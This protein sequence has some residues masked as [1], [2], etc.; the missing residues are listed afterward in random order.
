MSDLVMCRLCLN[1]HTDSN[2]V[3]GEKLSAANVHSKLEKYL[4]LVVDTDDNITRSI[5]EKCIDRL[6]DF[7]MFY[8]QVTQN[9]SVLRTIEQIEKQDQLTTIVNPTTDY[10]KIEM[11]NGTII[12]DGRQVYK[13]E[14]LSVISQTD[15]SENIV[16]LGS[17]HVEEYTD[18]NVDQEKT[19]DSNVIV[20]EINETDEDLQEEEK[21]YEIVE[22]SEQ[23]T[24][25]IASSRQFEMDTELEMNTNKENSVHNRVTSS[26]ASKRRKEDMPSEDLKMD[27]EDDSDSNDSY[28]FE[29]ITP[30]HKIE[31]E[32]SNVKH[33]VD[34]L[35][36][37]DDDNSEDGGDDNNARSV[38]PTELI[39]DSRLIIRGKRLMKYMSKFYRLTCDICPENSNTVFQK[40]K[41]LC[42]HYNE[43]HSIKGYVMCCGAKL[44][45][46]RAM[47]MHM[48]R[49]LQPEA[50][51]CPECDKSMTHPKILQYHI[52]N[53]LPEEQRPLACPD[54]PRRFSYSS[55]LVAHAISHQPENER[56]VHICDECGKSFSSPG[57]LSTHTSVVHTKH[58]EVYVCHICAK[59]FG[60]KG[61]LVY[62]LTTHQ[63]R[64]HQVQCEQCD[65]WLKNK[66]CLRKHMI[67]HSGIKYLCQICSYSAL[68][69]QC[70]RNHMRVQHSDEK[71]FKC[72]LCEKTFK[73]KNTLLNHIVQ[74]TGVKKFSC[75]FCSRTF[76]SSGNYYS[77][78]KRMHPQQLAILKSK[79]EEEE[80]LLR[81]EALLRKRLK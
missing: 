47:A 49:H 39:R 64:M 80:R 14:G 2:D 11:P 77:H 70:L 53:H 4:D 67:Q 54:C 52:Q 62:H 29:Q 65:K 16:I 59:K 48:C 78:R 21:E 27:Y 10:I 36:E 19:L 38:F 24:E 17:K 3:F 35:D 50:F 1:G 79:Q 28:L 58:D 42:D 57:R 81:E 37:E 75:Q 5:C 68:N 61:N 26:R 8:E 45:K 20:E 71:P 25:H 76:A 34:I 73:L 55:A 23:E 66:L 7:H 18:Q 22:I 60:C 33:E 43:E 69:P 72:D 31:T 56:A 12:T 74:H 44:I 40:L 15:C 32:S 41:D 51:K 9:Q 13:I 63:P 46:P 30:Q 6:E